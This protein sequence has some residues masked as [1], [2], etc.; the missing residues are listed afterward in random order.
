MV[1]SKHR[2]SAENGGDSQT[3]RVEYS[4]GMLVVIWMVFLLVMLFLLGSTVGSFLNV[5]IV[6][7]PQGR[8]LIR[9]PSSC[10]QCGKA[11]RMQDNIPLLSYWLLQAAAAPGAAFSMRC[12][13][14]ELLTG[15]VFVLIYYLEIARNVHHF[16]LLIWYESDFESLLMGVFQPRPWLVRRPRSAELFPDRGDD[17]HHERHKL[18]RSVTVCG[19]LLGLLI[20][21]LFPWPWPMRRLRPLSHRQQRHEL[22]ARE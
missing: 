18:P 14:I 20:A 17:H 9:P 7:L 16:H 21:M 8:S 22:G 10:G 11:I 13:W 19:V 4:D 12:L 15:L 5:C 1:R 3:L 2:R 6:R